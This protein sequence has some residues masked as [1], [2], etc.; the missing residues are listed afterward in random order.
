MDANFAL[1]AVLLGIIAL[2]MGLYAIHKDGV[3]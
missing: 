1:S 3:R 2:T